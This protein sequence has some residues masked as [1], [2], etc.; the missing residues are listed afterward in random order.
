[1]KR[2]EA[3][4]NF[5]PRSLVGNAR[6]IKLLG[7]NYFDLDNKGQSNSPKSNMDL[8]F[9]KSPDRNDY[10]LAFRGVTWSNQGV[11]NFNKI[12]YKEIRDARYSSTR[13]P[14]TNKTTLF[15]GYG[16]SLPRTGT[17]FFIKTNSGNVAKLKIIK[18]QSVSNNTLVA[19]NL[20]FE[21]E[22]FPVVSHPPKPKK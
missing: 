10:L 18:Y 16:N 1:M 7:G 17:V 4:K 14:I 5:S 2:L 12:K 22:V 11:V 19:R 8:Y 21:Y 20:I 9:G 13:N 3:W 15:Y 6:K